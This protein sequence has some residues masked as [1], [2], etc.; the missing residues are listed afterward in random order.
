MKVLIRNCLHK[1][2]IY[3]IEECNLNGL[4]TAF[5]KSSTTEDGIKCL[6]NEL[7]GFNWYNQQN[8]NIIQVSVI[9]DIDTYCKIK[10]GYIRGVTYSYIDGIIKNKSHIESILN[11]YSQIWPDS[12]NKNGLYTIHGDFS[13]DN[14]IFSN[15][16]GPVVIDWEHF[17]QYIAPIGFDALNLLFE[18][19]WFED[20]VSRVSDKTIE[21]LG[22]MILFLKSRNCI[23]HCY[24][25]CALQKTISFIMDNSYIWHVQKNKLPILKFNDKEI[26]LIDQKINSY[27]LNN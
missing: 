6:R 21:Y 8:K 13:M 19:L 4:T 5:Y 24:L 14:V 2:D 9:C 23:D 1:S 20:E 26:S 3:I 16:S 10:Y 11:H 17:S 7:Q 18:Q 27:I 22:S 12:P 25:N 15:D